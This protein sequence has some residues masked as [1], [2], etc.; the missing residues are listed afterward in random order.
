MPPMIHPD[1]GI[2]IGDPELSALSSKPPPS[3]S[4][5]SKALSTFILSASGWRSVFAE[6]DG[7]EI[8]AEESRSPKVSA[9]RLTIAAAAAAVFAEAV[10][11]WTGREETQILVGLDSRPTGPSIAD[12]IIRTLIAKDCQPRFLF[13]ASAPEIMAYARS[14][15]KEG[16]AAFIYISASHNPIGHNG[17]KFGLTDGGV[18][19]GALAAELLKDFHAFLAQKD[20]AVRVASLCAAA[21]AE[22]VR[23]VFERSVYWKMRSYAAYLSFTRE[24]VSGSTNKTEQDAVFSLIAKTA[25][26]YP[27]SILA[28]FNGS[29]RTVSPD[30]EMLS[31]VGLDFSAINDRPGFIAHR[32]VPEGVALEPCRLGLEAKRAALSETAAAKDAAASEASIAS[33]LNIDKT[34]FLGYVCDCDGDRGNLVIWDAGLG[35]ARSLEAQEVFALCCLAELAYYRWKKDKIGSLSVSAPITPPL[36]VAINDPSSLRVDAIAKAF[37]AEVFRAE[38]G[39]ANVVGLARGLRAKGY[40]VPILGEGAAGGN[41]THPSAVRDPLD[42][43]FALVK[44]LTLRSQAGQPGLFE[45]W[46]RLSGKEEYYREDFSLSDIVASLPRYTITGAYEE[47]AGIQ[48]QDKDYSALKD[49]YERLFLSDWKQRGPE[50]K[51]A[52][53]IVSWKAFAYQGMTERPIASGFGASGRGGL[54]ILFY[55]G[56]GN[57]VASLWMRASGTEAVFR[58]LAECAG[59]KPEG[60]RDLL[61]WHRSLVERADALSRR[62]GE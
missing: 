42:S 52:F 43:V 25:K 7:Q 21:P 39:E 24:V 10:K 51:A 16:I 54:K 12:V 15:V 36:A 29:A 55:D 23:A 14:A 20:A 47:R 41:I 58:L 28:D 60:E 35:R 13:I 30:R 38:V 11:R 45:I 9:E 27:I 48:I 26:A 33:A 46:C 4:D 49:R 22:T 32:I 1:T 37:G 18:L 40:E 8:N 19:D 50:L 59:D 6:N 53:G 5:L 44:L 62:E 17:L 31:G 56:E 61:L 3:H 34:S 2:V 57:S